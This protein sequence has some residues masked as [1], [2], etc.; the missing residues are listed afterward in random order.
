MI[1]LV[2]LLFLFSYEYFFLNEELFFII[3]FTIAFSLL[4][5]NLANFVIDFVDSKFVE[6]YLN[7]SRLFFEKTAFVKGAPSNLFRVFTLF[8]R[9]I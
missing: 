3:S 8:R 4:F 5:I 1:F 2:F 9:F 6:Q 7:F